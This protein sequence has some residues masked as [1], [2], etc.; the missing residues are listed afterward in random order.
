MDVFGGLPSS[1]PDSPQAAARSAIFKLESDWCDLLP[2]LAQDPTLLSKVP[3]ADLFVVGSKLA[4][5]GDLAGKNQTYSWILRHP[6]ASPSDILRCRINEMDWKRRQGDIDGALSGLE[7]LGPIEGIVPRVEFLQ[8]QNQCLLLKSRS[9]K[10]QG[11][12][13][14]LLERAASNQQVLCDLA[15]SSDAFPPDKKI[16]FLIGLGEVRGRLM[17]FNG[18]K[19]DPIIEQ[20]HELCVT[21]ATSE[22]MSDDYQRRISWELPLGRGLY[23]RDTGQFEKA[24]EELGVAFL[25]LRGSKDERSRSTAAVS[26]LYSAFHQGWQSR[27]PSEL[28]GEALLTEIVEYYKSS[29]RTGTLLPAD[30]ASIRNEIEYVDRVLQALN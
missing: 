23:Y 10:E 24:V 9:E 6:D 25:S 14:A 13:L 16:Y 11:D 8:A 4:V 3:V 1:N 7:G 30:L 12:A 21:I 2:R 26:F 5:S 18:A 28:G 19:S 15:I 22:R 20:A 17:A 29:M 27:L